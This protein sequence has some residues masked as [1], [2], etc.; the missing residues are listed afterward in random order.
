MRLKSKKIILLIFCIIYTLILNACSLTDFVASWGMDNSSSSVSDT[1]SEETF[2][3]VE[4][5]AET[6]SDYFLGLAD[7][8]EYIEASGSPKIE[9]KAIM[10][11]DG[12]HKEVVSDGITSSKEDTSGFRIFKGGKL[13]LSKVQIITSSSTSNE[14]ESRFYGLN[15]AVLCEPRSDVSIDKSEISTSGK[16]AAGIFAY[17]NNAVVTTTG[18]SIKT[19]GASSKGLAVSYKG[20]IFASSPDII[21]GGEQSH[22]VYVGRNGGT[23]NV[24]GGIMT[25]TG[26][27]SPALYSCGNLSVT[28]TKIN[29]ELSEAA[30]VEGKSSL[31]LT[32]ANLTSGGTNG[33]KLFQSNSGETV[34]GK[35]VLNMV[36]G[37]LTT[38][39]G[40]MFYVTNTNAEIHLQ[41]VKLENGGTLISSVADKWG[42][43]GENG[44]NAYLFADTQTLSGDVYCDNSSTVDFKIMN[45]SNYTGAVNKENTGKDVRVTIDATSKWNM[46]ADSY[47]SCITNN[48]EGLKNIKDN[49]FKIYYDPDHSGNVWLDGR[50]LS[51]QDG[52][53]L[54]PIK[55]EN[56]KAETTT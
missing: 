2:A 28:G 15:S 39:T 53:A 8:G 48:L 16:G 42:K 22:C 31:M 29:T 21:T 5:A 33:I 7:G 43:M 51:L 37:S 18:T 32:D 17:G 24:V 14:L 12:I 13:S 35:T 41:F 10:P 34:S 26:A 27:S 49:G 46:T 50:T 4:T 56:T 6:T 25:S 19:T 44:G 36:A 9:A 30:I 40:A 20:S 11:I 52:G 23:I 47:V 3:P 55:T 38:K 45:G 1:S 54:V